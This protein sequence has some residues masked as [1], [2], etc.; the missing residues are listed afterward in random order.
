MDIQRSLILDLLKQQSSYHFSAPMFQRRSE[1]ANGSEEEKISLSMIVKFK[2]KRPSHH[3]K[4]TK[5]EKK[6]KDNAPTALSVNHKDID[7]L[8]K[9]FLDVLT[10][11]MYA[12]DKQ[13][14]ILH[15]AR[16]FDDCGDG[17]TEFHLRKCYSNDLE[18]FDIDL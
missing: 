9:F 18:F 16:F 13:I 7:N 12:D 15:V 1:H 5:T 11:I 3:Y 6:L 4:H 17:C 8:C 14:S 10:G 2:V